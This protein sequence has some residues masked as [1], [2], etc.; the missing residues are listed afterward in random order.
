MALKFSIKTA[1]VEFSGADDEA[2]FVEVRGLNLPDIAKLVE[3]HTNT[4]IELY[5]KFVGRDPDSF[6]AADAATLG[7][8]LILKFPAICSDVIAIAADAEDQLADIKKLPPDVQ[9]ASLEKIANLT[10]AM[11]GGLGNFVEIV[12]RMA[13]GANGLKEKMPSPRR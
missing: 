10:F 4:C 6:S 5:D 11:Q 8:E 9:V 1:R 13:S 12:T 3:A 2:N 7:R